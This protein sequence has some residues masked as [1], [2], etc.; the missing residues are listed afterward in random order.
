MPGFVLLHDGA[1]CVLPACVW[2]SNVPLSSRGTWS[3]ASPL[4]TRR[5]CFLRAEVSCA[6]D[7][8]GGRLVCGLA[9][10]AITSHECA[11]A[12]EWLLDL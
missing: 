2:V 6:C 11:L 8:G 3:G 4:T 10:D 9:S 1:S 5:L 7:T 12:C